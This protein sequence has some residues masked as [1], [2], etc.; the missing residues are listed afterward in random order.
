MRPM[1]TVMTL[2]FAVTAISGVAQKQLPASVQHL[3][4]FEQDP[5]ALIDAARRLQNQ[6]LELIRWDAT[7]VQRHVM[8][9][10]R[11]LA[12]T[13]QE[14]IEQRIETIGTVWEYVLARYPNDA[15]ALNYYGEYFYDIVGEEMSA[16]KYWKRASVLDE[17]YGLADNNLGIYYFHIGNYPT[18]HGYLSKALGVDQKNPDY[19]FNMAQMYLTHFPDLARI[20]EKKP[21]K[22]YRE[23]MSFSRKAMQNAP[24]DFDLAQDYAVN[25]YAAENLGVEPDWKHAASAWAHSKTLARNDDELYF[26]TLNEARCLIRAGRGEQAVPLLEEVLTRTPDS[27]VV[28]DLM[29]QARGGAAPRGEV[30]AQ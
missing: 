4:N 1:T 8:N 22:L 29:A 24:D 25:F 27:E 9:K 20:L 6:Q 2:L 16:V 3:A 7:Q 30:T 21:K 18:G 10:E 12:D 11:G 13:K 19:L 5:D 15:R 17:Q 28:Q 14:Q 23:A 26:T